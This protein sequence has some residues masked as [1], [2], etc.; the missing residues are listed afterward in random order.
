MEQWVYIELFVDKL[1]QSY[2]SESLGLDW[3]LCNLL[4]HK[5]LP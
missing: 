3:I 4:I 1:T 2:F 5:Q